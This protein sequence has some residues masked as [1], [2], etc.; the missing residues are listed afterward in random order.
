MM[1]NKYSSSN[2]ANKIFSI[3]L[4]KR[5]SDDVYT[6][7]SFG[8][9]AVRISQVY[10]LLSD[11]EVSTTSLQLNVNVIWSMHFSS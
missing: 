10:K 9:A 11:H 4:L 3:P 8:P 6:W 1:L 5:V 2:M 7:H